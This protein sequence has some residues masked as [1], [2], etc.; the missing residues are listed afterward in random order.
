MRR[1]TN[2][3][4]REVFHGQA[5]LP[6][7]CARMLPT[8]SQHEKVRSHSEAVDFS[9]VLI[10]GC[11]VE[12]RSDVASFSP[13][14]NVALSAAGDVTPP[15]RA[16]RAALH[17]ILPPPPFGSI[18]VYENTTA[19]ASSPAEKSRETKLIECTECSALAHI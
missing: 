4:A 5:K 11:H 1:E 2:P 13:I 3:C 14:I 15:A 6:L 12:R 10:F 8:R 16:S 19:A 18:W 9:G 7:I 17:R